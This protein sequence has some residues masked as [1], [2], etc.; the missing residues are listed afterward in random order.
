LQ[1]KLLALSNIILP[2]KK[3][4]FLKLINFLSRDQYWPNGI[5]ADKAPERDASVRNITQVLCKAKLLG[6]V[7]GT[8]KNI[9]QKIVLI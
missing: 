8:K 2:G 6:I 7:S 5:L 4:D 1:K 3:N 9:Q